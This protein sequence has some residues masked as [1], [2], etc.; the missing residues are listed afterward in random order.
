MTREPATDAHTHLAPRLPEGTDVEHIDGKYRIDGH[1][2]GPEQLYDPGALRAHLRANGLQRAVVSIPPPFFRQG[3][4]T[5]RCRQWI[6]AVNEGL[7][8]ATAEH[9]VLLPLVYLP[10]DQPELAHAEYVRRRGQARWAGCA[11]AAGG[12]S[13]PLDDPAFEAL[14][15]EL[16]SDGALLMLHPGTSPDQRL[17]RHYLVNLL[18]NPVETAIAAAQLVFGAVP[19]R[20]RRVRFLLA[21]CGGAMPGLVGRW[22]RGHDTARPGVGRLEPPPAAVVRRFWVDSLAH[23]PAT[24]DLAFRVLGDDRIV[25]GSDW[26]FPMGVEDVGSTVAH[27]D[28]PA[29]VRVATT[30]AAALLGNRG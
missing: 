1:V 15:T 17:R 6:E 28:E 21:H 4:S 14:W 12:G 19:H 20:W 23:D 8:A 3:L 9:P 13:V 29:R 5:S 22:Q 25:L 18:G 10:L 11:G 26:P 16:D 7:L 24:V 27:L 2:V 30:N